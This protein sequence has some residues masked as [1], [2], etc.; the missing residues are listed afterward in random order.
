MYLFYFK[1][2]LIIIFLITFLIINKFTYYK[3]NYVNWFIPFYQKKI[4]NKIKKYTYNKNYYNN[5]KYIFD[6]EITFYYIKNNKYEIDYIN[7]IYKYFLQ[8]YNFNN[9]YFKETNNY[10]ES[11]KNISKNIDSYGII[12]SAILNSNNRNNNWDKNK[13]TENINTLITL[14][15]EYIF[16]ITTKY[17]NINSL[18]D[19]NNKKVNIGKNTDSSYSIGINLLNNLKISYNNFSFKLYYNDIKIAFKKL[20]NNE[21]DAIIFID[22]FPSPTLD[23]EIYND[24]TKIIKI[25]PIL[26]INEKLFLTQNNS[27]TKCYLDFNL[28][29][30]YLPIKIN[31]LK[32]TK[33]NQI[34]LHI[35]YL[36]Y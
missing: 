7:T 31:D 11:L 30:N 32:M 23:T 19:L 29:P 36:K 10:I 2:I 6:N 5:L 28:L 16:L 24:F 25:L 21:I 14:S 1:N 15:Y 13:Y 3:E 4:L 17:N 18:K 12:S 9:A 34:M 20:Y 27:F 26:D 8:S 35:K 22:M 33:F